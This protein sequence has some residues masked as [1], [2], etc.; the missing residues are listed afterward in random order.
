MLEDLEKTGKD[1]EK[2][3]ISAGVREKVTIFLI[4]RYAKVN[5]RYHFNVPHR[6]F[7]FPVFKLEDMESHGKMQYLGRF[8]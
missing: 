2:C 1:M 5:H 6:S 7:L 4:F 8:T 3:K